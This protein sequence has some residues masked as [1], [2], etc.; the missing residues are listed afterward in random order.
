MAECGIDV[1][2]GL[3]PP[4]LIS[5]RR[6]ARARASRSPDSRDRTRRSPRSCRYMCGSVVACV[7]STRSRVGGTRGK[8]SVTPLSNQ[9]SGASDIGSRGMPGRTTGARQSRQTVTHMGRSRCQSVPSPGK[10][11][12]RS[13]SEKGRLEIRWPPLGAERPS[14]RRAR[15]GILFPF[16]SRYGKCRPA[17]PAVCSR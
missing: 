8:P 4:T 13:P 3:A 16:L 10:T 7:R 12:H 17:E 2:P 5:N 1:S 15:A 14:E 9:I 6:N 11:S